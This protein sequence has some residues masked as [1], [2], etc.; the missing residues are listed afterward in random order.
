MILYILYI[1]IYNVL[2]KIPDDPALI[3]KE[4]L[5]TNAMNDYIF[6]V[7]GNTSGVQVPHFDDLIK[8]AKGGGHIMTNMAGVE[9]VLKTAKPLNRDEL[10]L[11]N[12]KNQKVPG[13]GLFG[14]RT[15]KPDIVKNTIV[16]ESRSTHPVFEYR[17]KS[18]HRN[19]YLWHNP[20]KFVFMLFQNNMDTNILERSL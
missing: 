18:T 5:E 13:S 9:S 16:S 20:Q 12:Y 3:K 2:Y 6:N 19:D 17:E 1:L 7:P 11:N 15:V 10:S 4:N 14:S 8:T